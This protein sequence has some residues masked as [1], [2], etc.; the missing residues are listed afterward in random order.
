MLKSFLSISTK[1]II[2]SI[3]TKK[4]YRL[5]GIHKYRVLEDNGILDALHRWGTKDCEIKTQYFVLKNLALSSSQIQQDLWALNQYMN[6]HN[7]E[8]K[9]GFFVEFGA[10]DGILRSNTYL[11]EKHFGWRGI[12]CEPARV[13]KEELAKNRSVAIDNRC[14]FSETGKQVTFHEVESLELSGISDFKHIG[15]WEKERRN[16]TEYTVETIS[17]HD[18][19]IQHS[20]PKNINYMSIDTEG[21]EYEILRNFPFNE[22]EIECFSIEHNFSENE[23]RLDLLMSSQGYKRVLKQVSGFDGWYVRA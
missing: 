22:W 11:L 7:Q 10:T 4:G 19:L 12:L 16:F 13:F 17:L 23:D 3:L 9:N 2:N 20:A 15:G 5:I 1:R 8:G 18:L 6:K 14:V 21:S